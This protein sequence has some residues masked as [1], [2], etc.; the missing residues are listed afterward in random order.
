[1]GRRRPLWKVTLPAS[2]V[3]LVGTTALLSLRHHS[4]IFV[5]SN[6]QKISFSATPG[7]YNYR[8]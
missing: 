4:Y 1:M 7:Y 8:L 5:V 2:C 6:P 3:Q